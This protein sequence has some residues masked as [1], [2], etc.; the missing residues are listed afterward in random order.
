MT[1]KLEDLLNMASAKDVNVDND[2]DKKEIIPQP[3][4]QPKPEHTPEDIQRAIAKAD[5]ID[6]ALDWFR[7]MRPGQ[8]IQT[9]L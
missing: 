1:K 9:Y 3:E 6:E 8:R 5:K 4:E 7:L 2:E